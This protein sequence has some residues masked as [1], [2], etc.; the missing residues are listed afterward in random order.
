[1]SEWLLKIIAL[2]FFYAKETACSPSSE[3]HGLHFSKISTSM[4]AQKGSPLRNLIFLLMHLSQVCMP[5][6]SQS[7]LPFSYLNQFSFPVSC[8]DN[9]VSSVRAMLGLEFL[10]SGACTVIQP[11]LPLSGHCHQSTIAP[12]WA[13]EFQKPLGSQDNLAPHL[14]WPEQQVLVSGVLAFANFRAPGRSLQRLM[15]R[16]FPVM[17]WQESKWDACGLVFLGVCLFLM[18]EGSDFVSE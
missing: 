1:M 8:P 13:G 3:Q 6:V 18:G 11:T 17:G 16:V 10:R 15:A 4:A 2:T 7:P 14:D 9:I 5:R 12:R